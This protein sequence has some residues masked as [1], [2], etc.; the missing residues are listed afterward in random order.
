MVIRKRRK[1]TPAFKA[2]SVRLCERGG[3]TIAE[4]SKQFDVSEKSLR[5]GNAGFDR[6]RTHP[7][8]AAHNRG[9]HGA[10]RASPTRETA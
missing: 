4:V 3:K 2:D 8:R 10:R 9:T 6:R 1:F 7:R 5:V